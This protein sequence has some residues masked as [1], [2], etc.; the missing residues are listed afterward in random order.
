MSIKIMKI[1]IGS[2][3]SNV[4]DN[5]KKTRKKTGMI[6]FSSFDRKQMH[7]FGDYERAKRFKIT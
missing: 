3:S 1:Y 2:F 5:I 6:F 7:P 4:T